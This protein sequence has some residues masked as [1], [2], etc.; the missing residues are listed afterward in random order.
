[1][2]ACLWTGITKWMLPRVNHPLELQVILKWEP[3]SHKGF[4]D[5]CLRV[6][7]GIYSYHTTGKSPPEFYITTLQWPQMIAQKKGFTNSLPC[8]RIVIVVMTSSLGKSNGHGRRK[9]VVIFQLRNKT[10]PKNCCLKEI[11]LKPIRIWEVIKTSHVQKQGS[12][13]QCFSILYLDLKALEGK[14]IFSSWKNY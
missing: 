6:N 12:L 2:D 14:S 5:F 10:P 7:L 4:V 11:Y 1:M 3:W 8:L 9:V 13:N